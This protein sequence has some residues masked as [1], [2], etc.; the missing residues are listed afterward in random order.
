[1]VRM[2]VNDRRS[3]I[4]IMELIL[5]ENRLEESCALAILFMQLVCLPNKR[6]GMRIEAINIERWE[7][8]WVRVRSASGW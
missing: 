6:P 4:I 2:G 7:G 8:Y 3:S 1:M 5:G